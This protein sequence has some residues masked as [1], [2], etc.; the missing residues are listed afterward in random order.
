ML[1]GVTDQPGDIV[2]DEPA[3]GAG[4][5]DGG[6]DRAIGREHEA[7]GLQ[8]QRIVIDVGAEQGLDLAGVRAVPDREGQVVLVDERGGGGLVIDREGQVVLVDERGGGGLVIDREGDDLDAEFGERVRGPGE[9]RQLRVAVR[10]PGPAVNQD[11]TEG[12]SQVA[13]QRDG[14]AADGVDGEGGEGLAVPEPGHASPSVTYRRVASDLDCVVQIYRPTPDC[15]VQSLQ[16]GCVERTGRAA[17]S[18]VRGRATRDRVVAAAAQLVHTR[19]VERTTLDEVR[20]A[21]GVSKPRLYHYFADKADLVRAVVARQGE[22]VLAAQ[23]PELD[24]IDSFAGLL[25]WR[26]KV[27][28]MQEQHG[29]ALGCPLGSLVAELADDELGRLALGLLAATQGGLLLA[30]TTRSVRPLQVALDM[31]LE[32]VRAELAAPPRQDGPRQGPLHEQ[33]CRGG[34]ITFRLPDHRPEEGT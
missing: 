16:A 32:R 9:R 19:G 21:T 30:Q 13:G 31:A 23:Q 17:G 27:N 3:D 34:T 4:G 1:A 14:A 20:A 12:V 33:R 22:A 28:A 5:V 29:C 6:Q 25:R 11:D 8:V 15:Q 2:G 24:A 10:A 18:T 7:G 26:D